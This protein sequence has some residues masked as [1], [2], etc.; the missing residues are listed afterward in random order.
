MGMAVDD[1]VKFHSCIMII[2]DGIICKDSMKQ[3]AKVPMGFSLCA[4]LYAAVTVTICDI[5]TTESKLH[6][7]P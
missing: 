2:T 7:L 5:R 3:G 6:F 1:K 4:M